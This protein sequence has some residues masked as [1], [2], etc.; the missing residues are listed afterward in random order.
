MI[1]HKSKGFV[2]PEYISPLPADEFIKGALLKQQMYDEGV[3]KVQQQL[4]T[5]GQIRKNLLK[6]EDKA[7]FDQEATKLVNALNKNAGLDFANKNN[8]RSALSLGKNLVNDPVIA[9]AS[10]SAATYQKMM[11]EYRKLDP[12]NRSSVND[13]FFFKDLNGWLKDG[14]TGSKL[15]YNPYTV[16]TD[17]HVKLWKELS[18]SLKPEEAEY[19]VFDPKD[20]KWVI[21]KKYSGVTAQRFRDAYMNGLSAQA[22]AQLEMEARYTLETGDRDQ[23]TSFY[24]QDLNNKL[25]S[26]NLELEKD[27]QQLAEINA[28]YGDKSPEALR[29]KERITSATNTLNFYQEK[30][31]KELND[32]DLIGFLRD[33]KVLDAAGAFAYKNESSKLE[34]NPYVVDYYKMQ[35]NIAEARAKAAIDI[36]KEAELVRRGLKDGATNAMLSAGA[37]APDATY[38]S[39]PALT[40]MRDIYGQV[41]SGEEGAQIQLGLQRFGE[42]KTVAETLARAAD[43]RNWD[44]TDRRTINESFLPSDLKGLSQEQQKARIRRA[45]QLTEAIFWKFKG[46]YESMQGNRPIATSKDTEDNVNINPGSII[47]IKEVNGGVRD[48]SVATFLNMPGDYLARIEE[49]R[50]PKF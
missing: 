33:D 29:L 24:T 34:A 3:E 23:I 30:Q 6:E 26:L 16:Y 38:T 37:Y 47:S 28:K 8:L 48:M 10:E 12:K 46:I 4:D 50:V 31:S 27:T 9:N 21:Q 15:N 42:G 17:E 22:R 19:P 18:T 25:T 2:Y 43:E 5:Y 44:P 35:N 20:N 11:D 40:S 49:I 32:N 7:Y 1:S 36:E 13:Y 39:K 41:Q 14:K 45:N